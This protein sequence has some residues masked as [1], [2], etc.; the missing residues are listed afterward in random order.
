[1]MGGGSSSYMSGTLLNLVLTGLSS[2]ASSPGSRCQASLQIWQQPSVP[3]IV[4]V[5]HPRSQ[6]VNGHCRSTIPKSDRDIEH[7]AGPPAP[8]RMPPG[9]GPLIKMQPSSKLVNAIVHARKLYRRVGRRYEASPLGSYTLCMPYVQEQKEVKTQVPPS[10]LNS[11]SLSRSWTW[12]HRDPERAGEGREREGKQTESMVFAACR[13][14]D[15]SAITQKG[16]N[17]AR[18]DAF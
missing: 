13:L 2:Q 12:P 14:T 9:I 7:H 10:S 1:M 5:P 18:L 11:A 15:H 8:V 4:T 16:S 6:L 17:P 3:G